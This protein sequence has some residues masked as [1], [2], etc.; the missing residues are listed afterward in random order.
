MGAIP[1][2][3]TCWGAAGGGVPCA[4]GSTLGS[5]RPL[6]P[7]ETDEVDGSDSLKRRQTPMC[8]DPGGD[9]C[10]TAGCTMPPL[11]IT[12]PLQLRPPPD[13]ASGAQ[14]PD[15]GR[16]AKMVKDVARKKRVAWLD[17]GRLV[18]LV[19][20]CP[21]DGGTVDDGAADASDTNC[22]GAGS[23]QESFANG[24][25]SPTELTAKASSGVE[26]VDAWFFVSRCCS[27]VTIA[28]A[29]ERRMVV[30]IHVDDVNAVGTTAELDSGALAEPLPLTE[31][32]KERAVFLR[33]AAPESMSERLCFL[34]E[35]AAARTT[36]VR[37]LKVLSEGAQ[38]LMNLE[39]Q[40]SS[41]SMFCLDA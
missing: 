40:N 5:V 1:T 15:R 25:A 32:E 29:T 14:T 18:R 19:L 13:H 12:S 36:F 17:C 28:T 33:Y 2:S 4:P 34:V 24:N 7:P 22:D 27:T 41:S 6:P 39:P 16:A 31:E 35:S 9:G 21:L 8:W 26:K 20:P 3:P 37:T 11:E 23:K 30:R 38:D 10:I